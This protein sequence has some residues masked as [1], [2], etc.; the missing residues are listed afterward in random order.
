MIYL[1]NPSVSSFFV[2]K[3]WLSI[4]KGC[5]NSELVCF[6]FILLETRKR[7]VTSILNGS[8]KKPHT[9]KCWPICCLSL[10]HFNMC[11]AV[12]ILWIIGW[13]G[14]FSYFEEEIMNVFSLIRMPVGDLTM[15]DISVI[16]DLHYCLAF[17]LSSN[18]LSHA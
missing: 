4:W 18:L 2:E 14:K 12:A 11:Y 5:C 10:P 3:L 15:N 6:I 7:L 8:R 13:A 1:F 17:C 9:P 16:I